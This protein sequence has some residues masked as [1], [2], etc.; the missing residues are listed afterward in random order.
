MPDCGHVDPGPDSTEGS[1]LML[2]EDQTAFKW[3]P[4]NARWKRVNTSKDP[5]GKYATDKWIEGGGATIK[6]RTGGEYTVRPL[7]CTHQ[8][9]AWTSLAG[10]HKSAL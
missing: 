3:D 6:T 7:N 5:S 4:S 8:R 9:P 1:G 2:K 10:K